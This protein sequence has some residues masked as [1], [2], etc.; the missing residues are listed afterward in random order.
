MIENTDWT[1]L[2]AAFDDCKGRRWP[3]VYVSGNDRPK[4]VRFGSDEL[5]QKEI[6]HQLSNPSFQLIDVPYVPYPEVL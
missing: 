3:M 5:A 6:A 2:K 4:L 1:A